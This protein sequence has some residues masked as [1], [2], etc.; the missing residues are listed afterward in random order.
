MHKSLKAAKL[1][2]FIFLGSVLMVT[3]IFLL[4][5]KEALFKS[6][7]TVKTYF[8][9]IEGLR[10]GAPVRLSGIDVGSVKSIDIAKDTTGRIIVT[11]RLLTDIE[12]FI[13]KDTKASIETEGL[14][15]NKV[16][17]LQI[18]SNSSEQVGEGG[19]ILSKEPLSFADVIEETQGIL[20]YTKQMTK[21][22]S[23]I[24]TKIN[25]GEGTIGRILTDEELYNAATDLT[26][27]ADNSLVN[28]TE[29]LNEVSNLFIDLG[30]SVRGAVVNVNDVIS[31]IDS[32]FNNVR[33]GEGV[34]GSLLVKG[35]EQD[36]IITAVMKNLLQVSEETKS[37]ASKLAENMEALK[38]NWLFKSY[39][40]ERGY[41]SGEE[42]EKE[43]DTK[44]I[45][46]NDKIKQLD[47]RIE[48]LKQMEK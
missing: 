40:E 11:M 28:I 27:R 35:T 3:I 8:K 30:V 34:I 36:S 5:N 24:T 45:E 12:Q 43:I 26:K 32:V 13:R 42:F 29:Q 10:N 9:N 39:F 22:L 1:G 23:E 15:G 31:Q 4:G 7:F 6:T 48:T 44:L 33:K 21:D 41:W 17:I 18:G 38:H 2:I 20:A 19:T 25:R 37:G 46:L 16:V 14:V 47:E